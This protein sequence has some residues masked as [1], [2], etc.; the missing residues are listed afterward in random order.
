MQTRR[1]W[2]VDKNW[3][4]WIFSDESQVVV[5]TNNRVYI[6]GKDNEVNNPCLVSPAPRRKVSVMVWGCV[7]CHGWNF[8]SCGR[9]SKCTEIYRYH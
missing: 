1:N 8:I 6:W 9:N 4:K 5:G 2:T 3:K 7:F